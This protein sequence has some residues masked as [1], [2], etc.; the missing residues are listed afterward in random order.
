MPKMLFAWGDRI[1]SAS[2]RKTTIILI[3]DSLFWGSVSNPVGLGAMAGFPK[4]LHDFP[5]VLQMNVTIK[6]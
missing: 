2:P 5:Q 4:T 3:Q 6:S 1:F